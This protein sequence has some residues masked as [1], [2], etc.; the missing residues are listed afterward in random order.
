[1]SV[2]VISGLNNKLADTGNHFV[3]SRYSTFG[4]LNQADTILSISA[5]LVKTADLRTHFLG[6]T[7]TCCVVSGRVDAE[8]GA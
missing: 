1:M 5:G 8:A 2:C 7:K 6:Y 4:S 3:D